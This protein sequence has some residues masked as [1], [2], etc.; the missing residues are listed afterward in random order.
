MWFWCC[1]SSLLWLRQQTNKQITQQRQQLDKCASRARAR[2]L[3]WRWT[4]VETSSWTLDTRKS[5]ERPLQLGGE[6]GFCSARSDPIR[7]DSC[8][9]FLRSSAGEAQQTTFRQRGRRR[10]ETAEHCCC[11]CLATPS[12]A[13][14]AAEAAAESALLSQ[15][16]LYL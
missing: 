12:T 7:L 2:A 1:C 15:L 8:P 5:L 3:A 6:N 10:T 13:A 11:G 14:V 16:Y 9:V 4:E